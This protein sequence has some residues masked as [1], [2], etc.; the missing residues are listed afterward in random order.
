M[1][2][3]LIPIKKEEEI[4]MECDF[5]N[6]VKE[7][8]NFH[9]N[10]AEKDWQQVR[11]NFNEENIL[12]NQI[13]EHIHQTKNQINKDMASEPRNSPP[14]PEGKSEDN[15]IESISKKE[16]IKTF[17]P[18]Y[19][20]L[21]NDKPEFGEFVVFMM[22]MRDSSASFEQYSTSPMIECGL[23]KVFYEISS[24]IPAV[25]YTAALEGGKATELLGDGVL[26]LFH[27]KPGNLINVINKAHM[28]A[29]KCINNTMKHV[30]DILWQRY[31]FPPLKIG[32]GLSYGSAIIKV[33]NVNGHHPKVIGQC[34][35]EAAKLSNGENTI[36]LSKKI[37]DILNSTNTI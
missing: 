31:H 16:L 7:L 1:K 36:G 4:K 12:T 26:I 33:M 6:N 37:Q 27:I 25:T 30:N 24:L 8:I 35:W 21:E 9:L 15:S 23:Q 17:I 32:I 34:V 2:E 10:C 28:A 3:K 18:G 29:E 14:F 5:D 19:P 22:D 13:N 11:H 20:L